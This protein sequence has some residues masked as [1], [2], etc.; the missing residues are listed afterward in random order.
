MTRLVDVEQWPC[1]TVVP[2]DVRPVPHPY[3]L[4]RVEPELVY[5]KS[6]GNR[7]F[8]E[9]RAFRAALPVKIGDVV[10]VEHAGVARLARVIGVWI[11]RSERTDDLYPM[12]R[13]QLL[14]ARRTWSRAWVYTYAG[15]IQAGYELAAGRR[16]PRR[17]TSHER[18]RA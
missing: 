4:D 17:I 14:T 7:Y 18:A 8:A 1:D 15:F 6:G 10:Y 12:F 2:N 13:V 16:D 3:A 9:I 5:D 11:K